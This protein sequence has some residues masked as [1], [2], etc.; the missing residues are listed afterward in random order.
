MFVL[1]CTSCYIKNIGP[2]Y[3]RISLVFVFT[4]KVMSMLTLLYS[5][6]SSWTDKSS[7]IQGQRVVMSI[8]KYF[9]DYQTTRQSVPVCQYLQLTPSAIRS[10]NPRDLLEAE[11]SGL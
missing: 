7:F 6:K 3:M 10:I 4:H 2:T 1:V 8:N 9:P 5:C 11:A